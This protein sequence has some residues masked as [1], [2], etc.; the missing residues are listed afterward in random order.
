M[1]LKLVARK[2]QGFVYSGPHTGSAAGTYGTEAPLYTHARTHTLTHT[3]IGCTPGV[4]RIPPA[5][6]FK[7]PSHSGLSIWSA[8]TCLTGSW[9]TWNIIKFCLS[10]S[11]AGMLSFSYSCPLVC[12]LRTC[13]CW[14]FGDFVTRWPSWHSDCRLRRLPSDSHWA[15]K[16]F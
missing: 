14:R 13:M 6:H 2:P 10:R 3:Y 12:E 9:G 16:T 8:W 5:A 11:A 4:S 1:T 15:R 7:P